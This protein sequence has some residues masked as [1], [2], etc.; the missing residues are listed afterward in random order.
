M[1]A[2]DYGILWIIASEQLKFTW[3]TRMV[4]WCEFSLVY[5]STHFFIKQNI[6]NYCHIYVRQQNIQIFS[7]IPKID[8][9]ETYV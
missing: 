5:V 2:D 1:V 8:L 3:N 7:A 4:N 6:E 9:S